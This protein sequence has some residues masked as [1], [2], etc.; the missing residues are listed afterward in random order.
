[1][2]VSATTASNSLSPPSADRL[3][4]YGTALLRATM[5]GFFIAHGAI[6]FFVFTP[7]G[8]ERYF[9]SLGLPGEV[10]LLTIAAELLGGLA[11]LLGVY[12]RI[13]A[14]AFVPL[15]LGTIALAHGSKGFMFSNLG[16]GWKFSAFWTAALLA[17][18][19]LGDGAFSLR[20]TR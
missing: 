13:V 9:A 6:E 19:L 1:L 15:M 14:L 20:R 11:L 8:T 5:G 12:T 18:A 2:S 3:T 10:G 17:Q 4:A 16:G 7:A